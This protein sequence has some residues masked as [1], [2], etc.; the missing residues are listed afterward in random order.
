MNS[1]NT[2]LSERCIGTECKINVTKEEVRRSCPP[3][4]KDIAYFHTHPKRDISFPSFDDI[5][6][7]HVLEHKFTCIGSK[8]EIRCFPQYVPSPRAFMEIPSKEYDRFKKQWELYA[9]DC[10][11]DIK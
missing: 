1:H 11:I 9:E 8:I 5:I 3:D 2:V 7:I 10:K 4:K 6:S